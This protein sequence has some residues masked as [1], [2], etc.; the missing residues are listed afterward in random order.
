MKGVRRRQ[1]MAVLSL[2]VAVAVLLCRDALRSDHLLGVWLGEAWGRSFVSRQISRWF[3]AISPGTSDLLNWPAGTRLW[4]IDPALQILQVP[5][6][7][8]LGPGQ[9]VAVAAVAVLAL[10]GWAMGQ[11]VLQMGGRLSVALVAALLVECA[12]YLLRNLQD[13]VLEAAAVGP[14]IVAMMQI[15]SAL[16]TPSRWRLMAVSASVLLVATVSPY[17]TVY[18]AMGCAVTAAVHRSRAWLAIGVAA[19]MAC[20]LALLPLLLTELGAHG[21]FSLPP[22]GYQLQPGELV[23]MDG[24]AV[25]R[26][27]R[28]NVVMEGWLAPVMHAF[29]GGM[30]VAMAG[31]LGL[32]GRTGRRVVALGAIFLLLG[33]GIP[34]FL[35]GIGVMGVPI[36]SPLQ[37]LLRLFPPTASLGNPT[38]LLAPWIV[39]GVLGFSQAVEGFRRR[40]LTLVSM[41]LLVVVELSVQLP[42]WALPTTPIQPPWTVLNALKGATVVFP[43]GDFPIFHPE[44]APKEAL[45]WAGVRE[46]S[47][48]VDYGRFR[49]PTDLTLQR[50]LS[51]Q[52]DSPVSA[53]SM[54]MTAPPLPSFSYLLVL[55]D[56]LSSSGRLALHAALQDAGAH[57]A[58]SEGGMSAWNIAE[59]KLSETGP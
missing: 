24:T 33:P 3:T 16:Q 22:G 29:P 54:E 53:Q 20:A 59:L 5:A 36:D 19:A 55:D 58:A 18:L 44:V 35:R 46:V 40:G 1:S 30:A 41:A 2:S 6:E 28:P 57:L 27:P 11:L 8:W 7:M 50:W 15:H 48:G 4:P 31:V 26:P 39:L 12:P 37:M 14:A 38:R 23:R 42:R 34:M 17:Y 32:W 49:I 43:S 45:F 10:S 25:P 56:R 21:R 51:A 52:A 13:A 9:G 47:L